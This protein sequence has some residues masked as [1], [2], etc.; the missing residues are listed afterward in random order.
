M[1]SKWYRFSAALISAL[2]MALACVT[3]LHFSATAQE[4]DPVRETN[5]SL[6]ENPAHFSQTAV[7]LPQEIQPSFIEEMEKDYPG[8]TD[9]AAGKF[10]LSE[11]L[12]ESGT[13]VASFLVEGE[14]YG[15]G[16]YAGAIVN[17][18]GN[19]E[20]TILSKV[21]WNSEKTKMHI[22]TYSNGAEEQSKEVNVDDLL[23]P[24]Y[25]YQKALTCLQASGVSFAAAMG[26]LASCS[27]L[28]AATVGAGC[29]ACAVGFSALGGT[30]AGLC[31]G[32]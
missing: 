4:S 16:S 5:H 7:D 1:A 9:Q 13:K 14:D 11:A 15:E 27:G 8:I 17:P 18:D 21:T 31:L 12:D 22:D 2:V 3:S 19:I 25:N 20:D 29:V 28:C 6:T 24:Q 26:I 30:A 32:G 23:I 10:Q